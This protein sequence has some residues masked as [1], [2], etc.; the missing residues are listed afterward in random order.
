[1]FYKTCWD[2]IKREM[3]AAF[4]CV[5]N[6]VTGP[7]PKLIGALIT[8]LPKKDVCQAPNDFRPISL[9]HSIAKLISK[10]LALRLAPHM[11]SLVSS[12]QSAFIKH[13]CIKDNFLYVRNLA[14]AYHRKKMPAL[15]LK[16]D[17]T[18]AFNLVSWA[19]LL[20][21]MQQRGFPARWR[22]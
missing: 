4:Q 17:I 11:D 16:L 22:N 13:R 1:V 14:R 19:Y 3:L 18:K 21:M 5:F 15:L 12:S 10:A 2:I 9:I 20:E 7:L 8:L 6:Q